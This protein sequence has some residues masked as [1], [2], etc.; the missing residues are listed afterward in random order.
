[1]KTHKLKN[2]ILFTITSKGI[3]YPEM[4]IQGVQELTDGYFKI[5][6]NIINRSFPGG[7]NYT[8]EEYFI[9]V[10]IF[11]GQYDKYLNLCY[12]LT[13]GF[14]K[15]LYLLQVGQIYFFRYLLSKHLVRVGIFLVCIPLTH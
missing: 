3:T 6:N 2:S 7:L 14:L 8:Q 15:S 13:S 5:F 11:Y 9:F 4:Y 10:F 1:M 12:H